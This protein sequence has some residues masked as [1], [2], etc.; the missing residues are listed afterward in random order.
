MELLKHI[1]S[2]VGQDS[3]IGIVIRYALD[4]PGFEPPWGREFPHHPGARLASYTVGT[5][6]FHGVKWPGHG[7]DHLPPYSAEVK[8]RV[9]LYL[10]SPLCLHGML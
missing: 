3:V 5:G 9:E 8:E 4:G 2:G 6:S 7:I 1:R 10:Y